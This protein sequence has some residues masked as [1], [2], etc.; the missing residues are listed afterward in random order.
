VEERPSGP[1]CQGN[2]MNLGAEESLAEEAYREDE[3]VLGL[4]WTSVGMDL[5]VR[6]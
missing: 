4:V 1:R 5:E 2:L 6:C 3:L